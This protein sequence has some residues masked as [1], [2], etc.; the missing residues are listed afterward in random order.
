MMQT[1]LI[2]FLHTIRLVYEKNWK[3]KIIE[4]R[5]S[6]L[7]IIQP[8]LNKEACILVPHKPKLLN[9]LNFTMSNLVVPMIPTSTPIFVD[10]CCFKLIKQ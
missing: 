5:L 1:K 4:C 9:P 8:L 3:K 2:L 6:L 10:S 7:S